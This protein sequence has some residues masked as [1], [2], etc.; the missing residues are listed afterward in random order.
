MAGSS[1]DSI[2]KDI[3]EIKKLKQIKRE[4]N[5]E[6]NKVKPL[7][8]ELEEEKKVL[9][10]KIHKSYRTVEEVESGLK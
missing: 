9:E 6:L 3:T 2:G 4:A 7:I 10:K 1:G 8:L 5:E